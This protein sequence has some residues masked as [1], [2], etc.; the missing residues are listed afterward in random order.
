MGKLVFDS[1]EDTCQK[2]GEH[3]AQGRAN[4]ER[5]GGAPAE[6]QEGCTAGGR[7]GEDQ[8]IYQITISRAR[9]RVCT[10]QASIRGGKASGSTSKKKG[11]GRIA[12]IATTTGGS[13]AHTCGRV[14]HAGA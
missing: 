6:N 7:T 5:R 11:N 4:T 14:P 8:G 1:G 2:D 13:K 3:P 9:Q 12:W 10:S